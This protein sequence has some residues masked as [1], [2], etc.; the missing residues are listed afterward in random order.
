MNLYLHFPFCRSKCAYCALHSHA[1]KTESE[2]NAYAERLAAELRRHFD[3]SCGDARLS[4]LY[5]GGGTPALCNLAPQEAFSQTYQWCVLSIDQSFVCVCECACGCGAQATSHAPRTKQTH[6]D[7]NRR[8][9]FFIKKSSTKYFRPYENII[10]R[11][12]AHCKRIVLFC[13]LK[14]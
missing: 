9:S 1:G 12:K 10:A 3:N 14:K 2:R 6:T 11:T 8:S 5:F 4:T 13:F 7:K